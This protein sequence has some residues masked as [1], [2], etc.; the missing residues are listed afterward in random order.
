ML[1]CESRVKSQEV[2][3][4]PCNLGRQ[5]EEGHKFKS[6][7]DNTVSL[8]ILPDIIINIVTSEL[9]RLRQEDYKIESN[10]GCVCVYENR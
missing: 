9:E 8:C 10:L 5:R 2:V 6:S 7:L 1:P 3:E 4:H